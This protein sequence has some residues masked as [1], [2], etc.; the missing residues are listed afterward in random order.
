MVNPD[1]HAVAF[2]RDQFALKIPA[3]I[4]RLRHANLDGVA[5]V[6]FKVGDLGQRPIDTGRRHLQGVMPRQRILDI[7]AEQIF[8]IGIVS[9]VPQPVLVANEL[10]N[11][12]EEGIFNWDPGAQFG[13]YRPE[14]FWWDR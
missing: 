8:T 10:R 12:P 1:R 6:M 11:V 7:H 4:K 13:I 14:T 2:N 3:P 9:Q 5:E